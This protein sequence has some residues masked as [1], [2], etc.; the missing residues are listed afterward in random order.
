MVGKGDL[1]RPLVFPKVHPVKFALLLMTSSLLESLL[2]GFV[3]GNPVPHRNTKAN[4]N[5]V[6]NVTPADA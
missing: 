3:C 5:Q 2:P 6:L 4:F 1:A